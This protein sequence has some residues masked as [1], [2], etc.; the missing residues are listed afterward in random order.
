[1]ETQLQAWAA[2][3]A[4]DA[5]ALERGLEIAGVRPS[6]DRWKAFIERLLLVAGALLLGAALIF[7]IAANWAEMSRVTKISL[8]A[9]AVALAAGGGILAGPSSWPGRSGLIAATLFTG[10]LLAFIGQTYQTGA[11]PWQLF[12]AWAVL[13]VPWAIAAGWAPLWSVL[14][15]I[16]NVAMA[17]Y[18]QQDTRPRWFGPRFEAATALFILD[19]GALAIAEMWGPKG[20]FRLLPRLAAGIALG[21]ATF[22]T[23]SFLWDVRGSN[24]EGPLL[25]A[26]SIGVA[27]IVY[28][29]LRVDLMILS[30]ACLASIVVVATALARITSRSYEPGMFLFIAA[31]VV[32][33]SAGSAIWLRSIAREEESKPS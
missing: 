17:L 19:A 29:R 33:M 7:F 25:F 6:A 22:M 26:L 30:M 21:C 2:A 12:A 20:E 18:L 15:V 13:C 16:A 4:L 32:G 24:A 31:V 28:R 10:G 1:M 5:K 8:L 14:L 11:D 9:A 27:Y 23:V 3:G